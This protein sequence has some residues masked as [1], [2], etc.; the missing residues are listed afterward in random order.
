SGTLHTY[1]D[2]E[3]ASEIVFGDGVTGVATGDLLVGPAG[4]GEGLGA[5]D[6]A[7]VALDE[8]AISNVWRTDAEIA[9]A[10]GR[11]VPTPEPQLANQALLALVDLPAGLDSD[12]LLVPATN[13][14]SEGAVELG[15]LLFF[16]PRLS[17]DG[18]IS[19]ATCHDPAHAWTDGNVTGVGIEGRVGGRNTPTIFNRAMSNGQFW[20]GRASTMEMQSVMPIVSFTEM[21]NTEQVVLAFLESVPGYVERFEAEYGTG[22]SVEGIE[23][24]IASFE[25]AQL[26]GNSPVDRFEDGDLGALNES[27]QRGRILFH[28][29]ARCSG[30]HAGS[31]FTDEAFHSTGVVV[32]SLADFGRAARS[33]RWR[34]LFAFKTPT[35]RNVA[36]TAPYFHDGSSP[37]LADVVERYNRGSVV[38]M[39]DWDIR[40]LALTGQEQADLVA[41]LEAL[42][43]PNATSAEAPELPPAP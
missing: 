10:A 12:E 5:G 20:D 27:E 28:T 11:P 35:L 30:C 21:D 18:T 15:R 13:P 6:V 33:G 9:R 38:D 24:A 25:R 29:K 4:R 43:D 41:F 14:P 37:T 8:V 42:S 7:V 39:H 1:V 31:N 19:C 26:T 36:E 2:G 32:Q 3:L 23:N 17:R 34:D 22:P 16:D 40:P